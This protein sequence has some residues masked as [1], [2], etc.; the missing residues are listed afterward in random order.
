M[1][2][3][4]NSLATKFIKI[5]IFF[6]LVTIIITAAATYITQNRIYYNQNMELLAKVNT[7]IGGEMNE[8]IDEFAALQEYFDAHSSEMLIPYEYS[9][10]LDDYFLEFRSAFKK[11]YPDSVFGKDVR[12]DQLDDETAAL[13]FRYLYLKYLIL[14][15]DIRD[16]FK[17]DYA[18]YIYPTGDKYTMCFMFDGPRDEKVVDGQS[19]LDLGI[20]SYQEPSIHENLW[21]AYNSGMPAERMDAYDNEYGHVYSYPT[22]VKYGDKVLGVILTDIN[23]SYVN[24]SIRNTAI[25]LVG[26]YVVVL[27]ICSAAIIVYV[28]KTMLKRITVLEGHVQQY[29]R[30]KDPAIAD[31]IKTDDK[32]EDEIT[33]LSMEFSKMIT[34]LHEYMDNLTAV[35]AEK[36]RIG[37]ELSIATEIQASMLPRIFPPFPE[38]KDFTL[39]ASMDPAKEVGGD[40]YDFFMLDDDHLAL[41]MA[42]V[43]GKGVPASLFMAIS[44]VMIKDNSYSCSSPAETLYHVNNQLCGEND[45]ALFVTV[46]LGI[47]E[48]STG[49]VTYSDAGHEYPVILKKSGETEIIKPEKKKPPVATMEDITYIDC[50][51]KLEKGDTLFLYTDG[52]PE[53]TNSDNELYDMSRLVAVLAKSAGASP[54]E[55]LPK[56]RADVDAFVGDAVQFDDLTMLAFRLEEQS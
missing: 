3:N 18:Y 36:E 16:E 11:N 56:V 25:A 26:L 7:F 48:L 54:T 5:F 6:I 14:F 47:V 4:N 20:T 27:G 46:W 51:L 10:L 39:F 2:K 13:Y 35:T 52:V 40:F 23:Y 34:R 17:L 50:T 33:S 22:P 28:R 55:L 37:A 30:E 44:K 42:D 49:I 43:S 53:A 31:R 19:Y 8:D 12:Y 21:A 24:G 41:V 38:R 9:E 29:A 32:D 15:D 1:N 45:A